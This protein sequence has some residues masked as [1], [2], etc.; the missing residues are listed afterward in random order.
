MQ[1]PV[2]PSATFASQQLDAEVEARG[3]PKMEMDPATSLPLPPPLAYDV[4]VANALRRE[5]SSRERAA[6]GKD[7]DPPFDFQKFLDQMKTKSAEPVARYL[8]S[9]V[10][11]TFLSF[12]VFFWR[13]G[14]GASRT[15]DVPL[16]TDF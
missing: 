1:S 4:A 9:F 7:R 16:R 11:P 13:G 3:S 12:F 2:H 14:G 6:Q 15:H 5:N 10:P 8:R